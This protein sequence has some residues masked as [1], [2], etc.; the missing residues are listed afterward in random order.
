M[1]RVQFTAQDSFA[2][3]CIYGVIMKAGCHPV[4]MC[5]IAQVIE[6]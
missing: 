1:C 2:G 3:N 6:H 4:D 5:A